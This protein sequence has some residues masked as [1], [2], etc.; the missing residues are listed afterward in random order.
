[1]PVCCVV[2]VVVA[3]VE[4]GN[5]GGVPSFRGRRTDLGVGGWGEM[6]PEFYGAC[7]QHF[8]DVG[9]QASPPDWVDSR[10]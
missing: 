2:V 9:P 4:V 10:P 6:R 8:P 7:A 5:L 1:M 3:V